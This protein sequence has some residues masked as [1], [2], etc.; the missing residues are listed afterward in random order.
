ML[1][2]QLNINF[3][4]HNIFPLC[5]KSKMRAHLFITGISSFVPHF[6]IHFRKKTQFSREELIHFKALYLF[7]I[8]RSVIIFTTVKRIYRTE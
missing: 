7:A 8:Y 4:L 2:L 3:V 5:H 6:P 1:K